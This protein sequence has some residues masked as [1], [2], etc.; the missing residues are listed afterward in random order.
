MNAGTV[1]GEVLALTGVVVAVLA[2]VAALRPRSV[3]VRL[4]YLTAVTSLAGPLVGAGAALSD[5]LTIATA[6]VLLIVLVV[7]VTGPILSSAVGRL[8]AQRDEI[9]GQRQR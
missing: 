7:A 4:H 6:N 1:I 8:N 3:Y 2:S 9:V 5:G